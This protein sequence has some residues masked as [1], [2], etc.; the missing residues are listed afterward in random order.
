MRRN[1]PSPFSDDVAFVS[2]AAVGAPDLVAPTL[3]QA[4]GGR[5]SGGEFSRARLHRVLGERAVLLVLDNF[6]HL[7]EAAAVVADLLDACP[8]LT[9]LVTSRVALRL[10]RGAGGPGAAAVTA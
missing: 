4:F 5:E 1:I 2:L 9:V 7:V 6:E 10:C 8:R 3:F